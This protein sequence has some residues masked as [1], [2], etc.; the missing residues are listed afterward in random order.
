MLDQWCGGFIIWFINS[1][2]LLAANDVEG[3][4]YYIKDSIYKAGPCIYIYIYIKGMKHNTYTKEAKRISLL[5]KPYLI[6][7]RES[8]LSL[9]LSLSLSELEVNKL[10][11][12]HK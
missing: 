8:H 2:T 4:K 5:I 1:A 6:W 3:P 9:S 10:K 7:E 11:E 12:K